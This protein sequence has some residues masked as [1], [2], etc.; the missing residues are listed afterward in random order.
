MHM[1]E[2]R[3]FDTVF[4]IRRILKPG[5]RLLISTPLE[6]PTVDAATHRDQRGLLFNDVTPEN[7]QFLFEKVGFRQVNRWDSDDQLGRANR[8]WATQLFVLENHG[9]HSLDKIEAILNRD[10]KDATYKPALFRALAELATTSYHSARWLPGG[11]VALPLDLISDKWLE[12][13]W[14]LMESELFIVANADS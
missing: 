3:L 4:N 2:E 5:G 11:N 9:S 1:P 8:R 10:R 6:G 14:P 13:Y 12:Y 7:F